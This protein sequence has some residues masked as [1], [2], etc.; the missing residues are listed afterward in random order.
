MINHQYFV[1][2]LTNYTKSTLYIGVTNNLLRR[3]EE[4]REG[5]IDCFSKKYKTYY[6]V[7]FEEYQDIWDA[8]AR[9]KQLKRWRRDKK[10]FLIETLNPEWNDLSKSI[11][12]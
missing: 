6:L 5:V 2:I 11:C 12:F 10:N 4:H 3:L 1:Y 9:E 8:I 7:Y